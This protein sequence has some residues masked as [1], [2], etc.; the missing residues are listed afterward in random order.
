MTN[1]EVFFDEVIS[2]NP[3]SCKS[4]FRPFPVTKFRETWGTF[5]VILFR[6]LS[7][8]P[9]PQIQ[10]ATTKISFF[11]F[12]FVDIFARHI[13]GICTGLRRACTMARVKGMYH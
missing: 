4:S 2:T 3:K 12:P 1:L 8:H 7:R 6:P 13:P 10:L 9:T 11:G 5:I